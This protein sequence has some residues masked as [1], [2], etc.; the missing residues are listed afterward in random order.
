MTC[1]HQG[2]AIRSWFV[3]CGATHVA[4]V[5]ANVLHRVPDKATVGLC[6]SFAIQIGGWG[7]EHQLRFKTRWHG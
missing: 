5:A 7:N 1:L 6:L 3:A 2:S 4:V